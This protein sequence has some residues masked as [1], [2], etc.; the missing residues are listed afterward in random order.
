[1]TQPTPSPEDEVQ[2]IRTLAA[3]RGLPARRPHAL[4]ARLARNL[5]YVLVAFGLLA[6]YEHYSLHHQ[7]TES[8]ACLVGA[9]GFALAPVRAIL[10]VFFALESRVL[11]LVHGLGGLAFIGLAAGG[12]IKGGP[13]L[14]HAA[15]APFAMMGAAQAIMRQNNPRNAE[16]AAAL[17]R[18]ATS[19]PEIERFTR[20]KDLT[21]PANI[22]RAVAVLSDLI[23]KAQALGETELNADPEFQSA[24]RKATA[25]AGLTLGLDS[26]DKAI[27][28]LA[29]NPQAAGSVAK[30]REQLA[31][32]RKTV[33]AT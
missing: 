28:R 12:T 4:L 31:A 5:L 7:S 17:R 30:L 3:E 6:A 16:Q 33:A 11:H 18:F 13:V 22:A 19:L 29:E 25:H 1:M 32:A 8:L 15:M 24:L 2:A 21:S 26:V 10:H 20:A 9:G 14:T 23:G 27:G